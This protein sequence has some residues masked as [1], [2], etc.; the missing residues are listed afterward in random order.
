MYLRIHLQQASQSSG[1]SFY[2]CTLYTISGH[3]KKDNTVAPNS[4]KQERNVLDICVGN[5]RTF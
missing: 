1:V 4:T 3:F 5:L 2:Y